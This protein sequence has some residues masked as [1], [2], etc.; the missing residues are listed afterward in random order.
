MGGCSYTD[1]WDQYQTLRS[2]IPPTIAVSE[3]NGAIHS[4][5]SRATSAITTLIE[6]HEGRS[7]VINTFKETHATSR[8]IVAL[9]YSLSVDESCH[10]TITSLWSFI[11]SH[12]SHSPCLNVLFCC[13]SKTDEMSLSSGLIQ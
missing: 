3:I 1:S 10:A 2:T 5:H 6:K 12:R 4:F 13:L 9:H 11:N 7:F 8:L